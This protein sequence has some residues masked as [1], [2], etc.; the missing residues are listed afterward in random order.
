[1]IVLVDGVEVISV[2]SGVVG[3]IVVV[4][5][6]VNV[7]VVG[8]V[9]N[10]VSVVVAAILPLQSGAGLT[11]LRL[12]SWNSR[13]PRLKVI[14]AWQVIINET[15]NKYC[16]FIVSDVSAHGDI[17]WLRLQAPCPGS[18]LQ[19]FWALK[20]QLNLFKTLYR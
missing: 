16:Y 15:H 8:V 5:V 9:V 10:V 11:S 20:P 17:K 13:A 18:D 1:M 2:V 4:G 6:V 3:I 12:C 7:A 19:V 14:T